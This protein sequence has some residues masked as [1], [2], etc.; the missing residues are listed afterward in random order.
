MSAGTWAG[1]TSDEMDVIPDSYDKFDNRDEAMRVAA[2]LTYSVRSMESGVLFFTL[3]G[4]STEE[5]TIFL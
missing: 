4:V 5:R 3:S 2:A 1:R